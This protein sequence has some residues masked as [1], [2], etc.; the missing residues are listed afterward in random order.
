METVVPSSSGRRTVADFVDLLRSE[1]CK[2]RSV[3]STYWAYLSALLFNVGLAALV[4]IVLPGHLTETLDTTRLSLGGVHL[5]QMAIGVLGVLVIASEYDTDMIYPTLSAVPRRRRLLAAKAI[6]FGVS[7]LV[8]GIIA[9]F[10]AFV[11]FQTFVSD[12]RLRSSIGDPGVLRA[13]TGGG[14]YLAVLGLL[15]VGLGAIL[16]SGAGAIAALFGVLF[17]PPLVLELLPHAWQ[18][19]VGPYVPLEAGSQIYFLRHE[20]GELGPW[21]GI[22]VFCL[23]AAV[24]L[25]AGFVVIDRRDAKDR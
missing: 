9:S 4:A 21:L 22:G 12:D 20:S 6:V 11:V 13:L 19:T 25:G 16:R 15:G 10:A 2:L 7:A 1:L 24:T 14:V 17:V 23:Y 8:V 3:R 5:S 18:E